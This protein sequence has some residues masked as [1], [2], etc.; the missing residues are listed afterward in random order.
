MTSETDTVLEQYINGE[1]G[2]RKAANALDT[3]YAGLQEI[4]KSNKLEVKES[5]D[6]VLEKGQGA[7]A[8]FMQERK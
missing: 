3:D 1:I 4:L 5:S 2:W 6:P 8:N 7:F